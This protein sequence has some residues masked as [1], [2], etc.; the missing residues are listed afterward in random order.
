VS[1][2]AGPGPQP[3]LRAVAEAGERNRV[4]RQGRAHVLF[5]D[6]R[7]RTCRVIGWRQDPRRGWLVNLGWPDGR[8]GWYRYDPR[9]I[10]PA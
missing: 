8:S 10:H 2:D 9:A 1:A 4:A 5:T 3:V 6:G 7:W